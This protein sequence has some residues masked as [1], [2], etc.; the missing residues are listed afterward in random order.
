MSL[1]TRNTA[2]I[3]ILIGV[4]KKDLLLKGGIILVSHEWQ[5]YCR[6]FKLQVIVLKV[7]FLIGVVTAILTLKAWSHLKEH[8]FVAKLID[9]TD[10]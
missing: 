9:S 8:Q 1:S 10:H 2:Y 7:L 5:Y 3:S 4:K 6:W